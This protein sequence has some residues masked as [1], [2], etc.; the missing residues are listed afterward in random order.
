MLGIVGGLS[1]GTGATLSCAGCVIGGITGVVSIFDLFGDNLKLHSSPSSKVA[2]IVLFVWMKYIL[3][4]ASV[5]ATASALS[6]LPKPASQV[7][8]G[9]GGGKLLIDPRL[10]QLN[11]YL[12]T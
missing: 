4:V 3:L 8:L 12:N 10:K 6:V 7:R 11:T 5:T 1:S 9:V 2:Y